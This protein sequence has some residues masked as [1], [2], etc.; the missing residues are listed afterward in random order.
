MPSPP[1]TLQVI[2]FFYLLCLEL[3]KFYF[4]GLTDMPGT[5]LINHLFLAIVDYIFLEG[6]GHLF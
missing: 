4:C 6:P 1:H 3:P 2:F 5:I